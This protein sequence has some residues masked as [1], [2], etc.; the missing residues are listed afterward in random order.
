MASESEKQWNS[1]SSSE[2][3]YTS[4]CSHFLSFQAI[5]SVTKPNFYQS[6]IFDNEFTV[7]RIRAYL[8]NPATQCTATQQP[9]SSRNL[10]FNRFNQSSTIWLGGGAPSSNGQ[11][12]KEKKYF[13]LNWLFSPGLT[14]YCTIAARYTGQA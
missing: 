5:F 7:K 4:F 12:W 6:E 9:G 1:K 14:S 10:V 2:K 8:P 13:T 3:S 11:S